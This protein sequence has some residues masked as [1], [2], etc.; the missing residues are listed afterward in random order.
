MKVELYQ[1]QEYI[2][3]ATPLRPRFSGINV[4]SKSDKLATKNFEH[5]NGDLLS[6]KTNLDLQKVICSTLCCHKSY[7]NHQWRLEMPLEH[8][9]LFNVINLGI[10]TKQNQLIY[11]KSQLTE[12]HFIS[13]KQ[14][15]ISHI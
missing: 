4:Q 13:F 7:P 14:L 11:L 1:L 15:Q 3:S 8:N 6:D 10:K 2:W 12:S 5:E 9:I